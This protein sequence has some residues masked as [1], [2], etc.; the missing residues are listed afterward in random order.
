[1]L[2]F[3]AALVDDGHFTILCSHNGGHTPPPDGLNLGMNWLLGHEYGYESPFID[4][5][6]DEI[7]GSCVVVE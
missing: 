2:D 6:A 1:M 5:R 3:T 4:E 7:P